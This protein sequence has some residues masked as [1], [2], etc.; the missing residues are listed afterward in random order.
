MEITSY[1][2]VCVNLLDEA[3]KKGINIDLEELSNKL[4]V[5]VVGTIAYKKKSVN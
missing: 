4:G 1:V 3:K 5:P 2:I